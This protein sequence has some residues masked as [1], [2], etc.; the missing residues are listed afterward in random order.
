MAEAVDAI[1]AE[2]DQKKQQALV[3]EFKTTFPTTWTA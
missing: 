2:K 1:L 3:D